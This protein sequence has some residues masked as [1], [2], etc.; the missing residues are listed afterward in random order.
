MGVATETAVGLHDHLIRPI[1]KIE[2]VDVL[3]TEIDLQCGEHVR[4][5]QA[6]LLRLHAIDIRVNRRRSRVDQREYTR[7]SR[8][9][10]GGSNESARGIDQRL[11]IA[12]GL[13]WVQ[14]CPL[15]QPK[16]RPAP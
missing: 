8:I 6:D 4:R 12:V 16:N 11:F 15:Q 5:R 10:V 7:E 1:E 2:V 14:L 3:R 13:R 9:L